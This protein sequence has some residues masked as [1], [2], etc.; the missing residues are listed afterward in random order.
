M[1]KS[2]SQTCIYFAGELFSLKHLLG[3]AAL[4][5]AIGRKSEGQFECVLPQALEQ[6][7]TTAQAIRNQ[8]ILALASCDL[9]LFNFDGDEVD[10]GTVVEFMIAKFLDIPAVVLRTDFRG[11]GDQSEHPWNLMLSFYPRTE[12]LLF[13]AM[14]E[15]QRKLGQARGSSGSGELARLSIAAGQKALDDIAERIVAVFKR[16]MSEKASLPQESRQAIYQW[17][18]VMPGA[19]FAD[20]LSA[21]EI[22]SLLQRKIEKG[23]L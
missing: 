14:A 7:E 11:G 12:V 2:T 22:D 10:S 5:D 18:R 16:L 9:G 23:L 1:D 3:N 4:A 21:E 8:D 6:R 17:L 20:C 15:Y 19:G 13:D